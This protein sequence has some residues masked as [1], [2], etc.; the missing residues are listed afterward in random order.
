MWAL[1]RDGLISK[2]KRL[3]ITAW[4]VICCSFFFLFQNCGDVKLSPMKSRGVRISSSKS[5]V[6]YL[7]APKIEDQELRFVVFLDMSHSMVAGVCPG[8]VDDPSS[9][10]AAILSDTTGRIPDES[11]RPPCNTLA[12]AADEKM[13]RLQVLKNWML[14]MQKN[15]PQKSLSQIKV[16]IVPFTGGTAEVERSTSDNSKMNFNNLNASINFTDNLINEQTV[17]HNF[18]QAHGELTAIND[19]TAQPNT[20][21]TSVPHQRLQKLKELINQDMDLLEGQNKLKNSQYQVVFI[22][23]GVPKPAEKDAREIINRVW[24]YKLDYKLVEYNCVN[25]QCQVRQDAIGYSQCI[26]NSDCVKWI[27]SM[28][29]PMGFLNSSVSNSCD[30][31]CVKAI[32]PPGWQDVFVLMRQSWGDVMS[33]RPLSILKDIDDIRKVFFNRS[34]AQFQFNFY[35]RDEQINDTVFKQLPKQ[36]I[37]SNW[38]L[39]AK[40]TFKRASTHQRIT[41]SKDPRQFFMQTQFENSFYIKKFIVINLNSRINKYGHL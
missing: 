28:L 26:T 20:M 37:D 17:L 35:H 14:D 7:Q 6:T 31:E 16:L 29:D 30:P 27:N 15:I 1:M 13:F 9:S 24:A 21:G 36:Y 25:N 38:I 3:K 11:S 10:A 34:E 41:S 33:N 22:S 40:E 4:A 18:I 32:N 5:D 8:D 23:D 39:K 12:L 19:I 2:N